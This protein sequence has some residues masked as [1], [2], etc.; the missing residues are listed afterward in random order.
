MDDPR[1]G[2]GRRPGH[3]RPV[4]P[5]KRLADTQEAQWVAQE[6][7]FV[8][9]QAKKKAEIRVKDGRARPID[10]LAVTLRL[11]DTERD[12]LDDEMAD[13]DLEVVDPEGVFE[14]LSEDQIAELEKDID[15][16][17]ALEVKRVNRD[18]WMVGWSTS[19]GLNLVTDPFLADDEG[20]LPGPPPKHGRNRS[21]DSSCELCSSRCRQIAG[22]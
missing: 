14:G 16:Y 5:A 17:I 10:W 2:G 13:A 15:T 19:G 21:R 12:A 9:K 7:I 11:I 6:D 3:G 22:A 18:Y 8:L 1:R 4:I 20:D